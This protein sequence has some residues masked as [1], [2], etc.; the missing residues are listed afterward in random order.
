MREEAYRQY[1]TGLKLF[2]AGQIALAY[3]HLQAAVIITS[4]LVD[5]SE[6]DELYFILYLLTLTS[7][8][9][10][11]GQA[12][13]AKPYYET[14]ITTLTSLKGCFTHMA[15]YTKIM[16]L[17]KEIAEHQTHLATGQTTPVLNAKEIA[18][19]ENLLEKQAL[20]SSPYGFF[21]PNKESIIATSNALAE[22]IMTDENK[23]YCTELNLL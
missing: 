22:Q 23:E 2:K 12:A 4:T 11:M 18:V 14:A 8:Y 21:M 6:N 15:L 1:A 7:A 17:A 10:H 16:S 20:S 3:E 19:K 5:K 9:Y 13:L